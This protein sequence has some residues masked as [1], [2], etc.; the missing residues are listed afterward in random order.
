[1]LGAEIQIGAS[2]HQDDDAGKAEEGARDVGGPDPLARQ[3]RREQHDEERP[4]VVDEPGFGRR[5]ETQRGEVERVIAEQAADAERPHDR[6]LPERLQGAA[7]GDARDE[8]DRPADGERHGRKLERRH[9]SGRGGE[10]REQ[11]PERD[12]AEADEGGVALRHRDEKPSP[13]SGR[14]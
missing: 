11:R 2:A 6:P 3:Q 7:A 13:A 4:E 9:G 10:E 14:G 1:M 5:R 8:A 12:G